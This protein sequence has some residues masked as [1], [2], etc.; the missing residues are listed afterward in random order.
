LLAT[1][2]AHID[3]GPL[4]IGAVLLGMIY[5]IFMG[6]YAL[7]TRTP[8]SPPRWWCAVIMPR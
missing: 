1:G 3:I 8:P 7:A 6:L 4:V 5:G 2:T